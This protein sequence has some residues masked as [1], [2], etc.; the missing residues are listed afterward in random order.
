MCCMPARL[1]IWTT[2]ETTKLKLSSRFARQQRSRYQVFTGEAGSC[3]AVQ[4]HL[5][6]CLPA[7]LPAHAPVESLGS[8]LLSLV[9]RASLAEHFSAG[10]GWASW[11]LIFQQGKVGCTS[12]FRSALSG[13]GK[14]VA[15]QFGSALFG[16]GY[17][18]VW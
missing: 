12:R 7:R 3:S 6:A 2:G 15:G 4:Y 10:E 11:Q 13:W 16:S 1:G 5:P 9:I 17:R 14:G 18:P 8:A